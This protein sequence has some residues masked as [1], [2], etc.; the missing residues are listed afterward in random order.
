MRSALS[1]PRLKLEAS[2]FPAW[3]TKTL[4][5]RVHLTMVGGLFRGGVFMSGLGFRGSNELT[6]VVAG[7]V[8]MTYLALDYLPVPF[9]CVENE[10]PHLLGRSAVDD[11]ANSE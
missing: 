3:E 9:P 7:E 2:R 5:Q 1:D 6:E 8:G 4:L 10:V 11:V